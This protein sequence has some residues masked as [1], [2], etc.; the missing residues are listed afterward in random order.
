M[1]CLEVDELIEPIASGDLE[2]DAEVGAHLATCVGCASA[3]AAARQIET[4]LRRQAT[5]E[6]SAAFTTTLMARLR[7]ERWRSEQYLDVAF[8]VAVALALLVGVGGL[9][10]VLSASG[11][12]ALS[13]EMM[14]SFVEST[15]TVLATSG[16]RLAVYSLAAGVFVSG[17][18]VWWWAE[19]GFEI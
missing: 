17:L 18:A 3:L 9:W 4:L 10:M 16:P 8:N 14:R 13:A 15:G 12:A 11:L 7:R 19:H 5:A 1:D 6:P 2:P